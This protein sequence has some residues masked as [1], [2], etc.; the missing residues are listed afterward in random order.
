MSLKEVKTSLEVGFPEGGL[1]ER[2]VRFRGRANRAIG[3]TA[4]FPFEDAQFEVVMLDGAA[5]S[6][7]MVKEAH[8]VLRPKGRL[9]FVVP[10]KTKKQDGFTLPEIYGIVRYGFN[11]VGVERPR[12]RFLGF[13]ERTI[14][15]TAEKKTWKKLENCFRPYV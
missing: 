12:W 6:D 13:G 15:I 5:V 1:P 9:Y 10:E 7:D 14:T 8:R 4:E 3:V 2:F 11:I